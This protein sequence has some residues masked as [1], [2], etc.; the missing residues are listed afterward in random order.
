[1]KPL[2]VFSLTWLVFMGMGCSDPSE[3]AKTDNQEQGGST[4]LEGNIQMAIQSNKKLEWSDEFEGTELDLSKWFFSVSDG[5]NDNSEFPYRVSMKNMYLDG[6]GHLIRK[7]SKDADG[8]YVCPPNGISSKNEFGYGY[9][10]TRVKFSTQPGWHTA[11]WLSGE[12]YGPKDDTFLYPQEFDIYEDFL[13]PK[14]RAG[15]GYD[16]AQSYWANAVDV[17]NK[18]KLPMLQTTDIKAVLNQKNFYFPTME[19]Y[20]EWHTIGLEWTPLEHIYFVDGIETNR[21]D[22]TTVPIT[23]VPQLFRITNSIKLIK[24]TKP[25]IW[26]GWIEEAVLPDSFAVDYV[27][28]YRYDYSKRQSPMVTVDRMESSELQRGDTARFE[29]K[30]KDPSSKVK[31]IYLFSKGRIRAEVSFETAREE[32]R[33]VFKITNLFKGDNTV[34]AF[35]KSEDGFVGYSSRVFVK[36]K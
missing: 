2:F 9:Y 23:N 15:K 11:V 4:A 1:M 30:V 31:T 36:V 6:Q 26:H 21:M 28:Y 10:E 3:P 27:R 33:H 8:T 29:V 7:L 12:P 14:N 32:A 5:I 16:I 19:K 35:T 13:K 17:N 24:K 18:E 25:T 34:M 22:Y 20:Q